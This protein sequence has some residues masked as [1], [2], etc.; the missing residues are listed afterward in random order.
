MVLPHAANSIVFFLVAKIIDFIV[1]FFLQWR[2][3]LH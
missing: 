3:G 1:H 2:F